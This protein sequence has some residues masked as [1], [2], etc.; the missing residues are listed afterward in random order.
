ME[1][2]Y[3]LA[4]LILWGKYSKLVS[5]WLRCLAGRNETWAIDFTVV[6]DN[7]KCVSLWYLDRECSFFGKLPSFCEISLVNSLSFPRT[8]MN[9]SN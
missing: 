8:T 1:A 9:A 4:R 5:Q 7:L 3:I 6:H 2:I